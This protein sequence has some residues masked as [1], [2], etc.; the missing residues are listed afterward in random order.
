MREEIGEGCLEEVVTEV[1]LRMDERGMAGDR[2]PAGRARA[3]QE[4]GQYLSII[5]TQK[6]P[7]G[8]R[9]L[10]A[11]PR[12]LSRP[13]ERVFL[14]EAKSSSRLR[15]HRR[16]HGAGFLPTAAQVPSQRHAPA[17]FLR[18]LPGGL[19]SPRRRGA[20]ADTPLF[21]PMVAYSHTAPPAAWLSTWCRRENARV[22]L[23][24][25]KCEDT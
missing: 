8:R 12:W 15:R 24:L 25:H 19:D 18:V 2:G 5:P 11:A 7:E 13:R 9:C 23:S 16:L 22:S 21:T 4:A 3:G 17:R 10:F 6:V 1:A 20:H 14:A